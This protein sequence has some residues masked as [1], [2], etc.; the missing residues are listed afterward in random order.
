MTYLL[1][2]TPWLV[3]FN[4]I[5]FKYSSTD[6]LNELIAGH[7]HVLYFL[8]IL[9]PANA[10]FVVHAARRPSLR[11]GVLCGLVVV[12]SLPLGWL[13]LN[14]GLSPVVTKYG[15]VF[16]GVDFLLGPDREELLS[17]SILM[18]RWF[19]VQTIAVAALALG[20]QVVPKPAVRKR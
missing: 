18:V 2:A 9:I 3:V 11:R 19:A 15:R 17:D 10:L 7:G 8:L 12:A 4:L 20:I 6:N 16:S 1:A 13:L 5:A 14:H